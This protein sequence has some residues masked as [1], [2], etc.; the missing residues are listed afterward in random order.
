MNDKCVCGHWF[1]RHYPESGRKCDVLGCDCTLSIEDAKAS[2]LKIQPEPPP[3]PKPECEAWCSQCGKATPHLAG[4]YPGSTL[5]F[6]SVCGW[7][8]RD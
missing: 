5:Y 3:A 4:D 7:A 8:H 2:A 1:E 6:C